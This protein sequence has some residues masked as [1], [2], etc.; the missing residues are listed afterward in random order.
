MLDQ[1][2]K[3]NGNLV[4]ERDQ[5]KVVLDDLHPPHL[6]E[7]INLTSPRRLSNSEVEKDDVEEVVVENIDDFHPQVRRQ[8]INSSNGN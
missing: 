6:R 5:H 7:Q 8:R 3:E 4:L 1:C 2:R